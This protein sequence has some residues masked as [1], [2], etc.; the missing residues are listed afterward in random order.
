MVRLALLATQLQYLTRY[1]Q[2]KHVRTSVIGHPGES[3]AVRVIDQADGSTDDGGFKPFR[4]AQN[5]LRDIELMQKRRV[6]AI[7]GQVL[8]LGS[9]IPPADSPSRACVE[10]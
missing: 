6:I 3:Y 1:Y 4:S 8:F 7:D 9:L 5:T 2:T 10:N